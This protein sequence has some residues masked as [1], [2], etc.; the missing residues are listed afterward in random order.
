MYRIEKIGENIVYTKAT[1]IFTPEEA[2]NFVKDFTNFIENMEKFSTLVDLLDATFLDLES[3]DTI[4]HL[5]QDH[6][7]RLIRSTFVISNNP[8]LKKEFQILLDK[9]ESPKRKIVPNLDAAKKWLGIEEIVIQ[10]E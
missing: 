4:L 9:A 8:P 1:G 3:F 10:K 5:L 6:N 2:R 7:K